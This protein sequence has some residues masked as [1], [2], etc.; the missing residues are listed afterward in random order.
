MMHKALSS[1]K[2]HIIVTGAGGWIGRATLA[3]LHE[4]L[5]PQ[6]F[7]ERVHAYASTA[8]TW[9]LGDTEVQLHALPDLAR[10]QAA[11]YLVLHLAFLTR[12]KV[13]LLGP[14]AFFNINRDIT[15]TL[16]AAVMHL[17]PEAMF[18]ASSG[19]VYNRDGSLC[20]DIDKNP[21]GF[22]KLKDEQVFANLGKSTG[23]RVITSRIFNIAGPYINKTDSYVLPCILNDIKAGRPITLKARHP[24][25]RSY[26]DV[27]DVMALAL[28]LLL[29]QS[30]PGLTFD[31]AGDEETEIGDL[32]ARCCAV[33]KA[34]TPVL[35]EF[36]P[37]LP[38]DRY[39]GDGRKQLELNSFYGIQPRPLDEQI[40]RTA[41]AL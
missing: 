13:A 30:Q 2:Q 14:E 35:R 33:M 7:G 9:Q 10:L 24:V 23:T 32:A 29:D 12:D 27:D 16:S 40:R 4:I 26:C 18:L 20:D 1:G 3:L 22:L 17:R 31:T 36:D 19:A 41:K 6:A 5:G 11:P 15:E 28:T 37:S 39:V 8:R 34:S 38:P 25:I 21:Y